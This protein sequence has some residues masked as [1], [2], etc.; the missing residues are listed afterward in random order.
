MVRRLGVAVFLFAVAVP[1]SA[2]DRAVLVY[3]QERWSLRR[4]FHTPEQDAFMAR[5][6]RDYATEIHD[7]VGTDD[8]LFGL[9]VSGAK[10]LVISGHGDP[11]AMSMRDRKDRTLDSADRERLARFLAQL[12]DEATILLQSCHTGRGFAHFVKE[13][14]GPKRRVIAARGE[15]P[16]DGVKIVSL[17]PFDVRITCRD[18]TGRTWDCTLRL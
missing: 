17:I 4:V 14:A 10:L 11:Y 1:L 6:R 8:A 2:R 16:R 13:L 9:D 18:E 5:I 3:P 15:I 12:D 7:R